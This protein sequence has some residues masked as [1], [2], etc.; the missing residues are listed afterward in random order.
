MIDEKFLEIINAMPLVSVDLIIKN[1]GGEVLLGNRRNRPARGYWFVPGGRIRKNE[2]IADAVL[3][4]S[5]TELGTPVRFYKAKL[6]GGYNHIH[7]DNYLGIEGINTHYVVLAY[8]YIA[9]KNVKIV[10]DDQHSDMQWWNIRELL[11][12][13]DVHPYTKEYFK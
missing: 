2:K 6:L 3:R 4:I 10:T 8:E 11:L 13:K 7:D 1:E 5:E 12:S 9:D